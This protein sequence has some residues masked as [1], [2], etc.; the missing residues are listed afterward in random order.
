[1]KSKLILKYC[2]DPFLCIMHTTTH[3]NKAEISRYDF[4]VRLRRHVSN[5]EHVK[6]TPY[7][8]ITQCL[9]L[10]SVRCSSSLL[11]TIK[12][13]ATRKLRS[14][15]Y[16]FTSHKRTVLSQTAYFSKSALQGPS[17]LQSTYCQCES[18]LVVCSCYAYARYIDDKR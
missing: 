16:S 5:C 15:I 10:T 12:Q 2:R 7:E 14:S 4:Q 6:R 13:K 8:T 11:T 3:S 9:R 1:M 18:T 17:K